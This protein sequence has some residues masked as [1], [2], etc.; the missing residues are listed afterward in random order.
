DRENGGTAATTATSDPPET[1]VE[2]PAAREAPGQVG[3]APERPADPVPPPR[4]ETRRDKMLLDLLPV[5]IL[6]YRL[7]RLLYANAAFLERMGYASLHAL[8]EAGG[9]DALYV[10]PGVSIASSTSGTGT[11]VTISASQISPQQASSED[12]PPPGIDAHLFTISWD[13]DSALA[14]IFSGAGARGA[15]AAA[16]IAKTIPAPPPPAVGHG[17]AEE[18]GAILDTTAEGVVMFDAAGNIN[19]CNRSAE[20]LFGYDGAELLRRN[21][22]ELFAPESQ[23]VVKD[24]LE[25]IRGTGVASLLDHGR[26]VLGRAS[27]GGLIPLT[28]TMG[29]TRPGGPNFF[30]VFRDLSQT[31]KSESELREAR[32]LADRAASA[33]ADM[34]A[35]ISHE[36]R[37]PL[38]AIIGFAEVMID[39][40]FGALGNERYVEYMMDIRASGE[41]VISI[42]DDLLD[43]S[44]IETGKLD[45]AFANQNLNNTVESCVAV[46]QPQA[47]RERIIIRTSL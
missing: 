26:D 42:I 12:A 15:D 25:S 36:V 35:R 14:L 9:V 44:R 34:L 7:D 18:L 24:Y 4:G 1:M 17:H 11:P 21:L 6:I 16:A 38:N 39:Q 31:R 46:M 27:R 8:E 45:L 19:L 41:R 20:A 22:T 33:K 29:R 32:R 10:E 47:N 2:Q 5:G 23:R 37:T 43:L 40:R 13:D 28:M 3:E 30:A